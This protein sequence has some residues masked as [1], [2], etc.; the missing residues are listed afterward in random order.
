MDIITKGLVKL[1]P[2]LPSGLF[3][4]I[5]QGWYETISWLDDEA[6]MRFMNYGW[7]P[8]KG[9]RYQLVLPLAEEEN[10]Y[11]IQLYDYLAKTIPL[12]DSDVLEIGSGRGGGA[13]FICRYH[14]PA[15]MVGLD[16]SRLAIR[17]CRSFYRHPQL[18]FKQGNAQS[19]PFPSACFDAVFNV[20]S[21]HC[22]PSI[23]QFS[24]EVF[25]VLRPSGYFLFA[26]GR[27]RN[28]IEP[29]KQQLQAPGFKLIEQEDI[30]ANVLM[31]LDLDHDR[32]YRLIRQKAPRLLH[33]LMEEFA[34]LKNTKAAYGAMQ[35]GRI[36]Y[37]KMIWQRC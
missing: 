37:V 32:K 31:A 2:V 19:L 27:P 12:S 15:R 24:R 5:F 11:C 28:Q 30:T 29:L 13:D 1:L 34:G 36:S 35:G 14:K 9:Q 7:A 26:D 4:F 20:E 16:L 6:L 3:Q 33:A 18:Y 21:S 25:R 23:P 17:F 8:L 10:R 22:Y